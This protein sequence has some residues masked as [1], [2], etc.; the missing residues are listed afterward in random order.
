VIKTALIRALRRFASRLP[1]AGFALAWMLAWLSQPL[2]RGVPEEEIAALVPGLSPAQLRA[3]RRR[4]WSNFLMAEAIDGA[5]ERPGGVERY[6]RVASAPAA[7]DLAAPLIVTTFHIGAYAAVAT[8]LDR[9]GGE[10]VV[11][12]RGRFGRQAG[13]T[14]VR[15][16]DDEWER[17]RTF[18]RGVRALRS[19]AFVFTTLD[20]Y[21]GSTIEVPMFGR[22]ISLARGGFAMARLSGVP[23][24]PVAVR[25]RGAAVDIECGDQI[26]PS[27]SEQAM[28]VAVTGWLEDYLRR[29]PGEISEPVVDML[30]QP[31]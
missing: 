2:R 11:V 21:D 15:A 26:P 4:T 24:L 17:A 10:V 19:G 23:V 14:L 31:Q 22:T 6:P 12:H 5:L 27:E 30:R 18:H 8:F 20:G 28:A 9:L 13:M 29:F 3:A 7:A 16:G 1:R 25:W